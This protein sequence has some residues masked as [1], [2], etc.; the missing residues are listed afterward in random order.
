MPVTTLFNLSGN[1]VPPYSA[2]GLTQT[3][4]PLAG[5]PRR[6]INGTLIDLSAPQFRKYRSTVNCSDQ[7]TPALEGVYPGAVVEV[8]CVAELCYPTGGTPQRP[9]VPGSSR[10]E[11]GFVFYR[12][13]LSMMVIAHNQSRDEYQSIIGWGLELEEV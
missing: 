8:D 10:E 9:V 6:T 12:P 5:N 1:G 11:S 3:L 4:E 7:Q 13:R 2:R